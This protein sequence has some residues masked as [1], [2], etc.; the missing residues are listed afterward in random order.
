MLRGGPAELV[1]RYGLAHAESYADACHLC[2]FAREALRL[3]MPA[4]IGPDQVFGDTQAG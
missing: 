1:R 3:Q 4:F 2:Y